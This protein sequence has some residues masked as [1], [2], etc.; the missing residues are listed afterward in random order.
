M[1]ERVVP[2][3]F[4]LLSEIIRNEGTKSLPRL[5]TTVLSDSIE[6]EFDGSP[7]TFYGFELTKGNRAKRLLAKNKLNLNWLGLTD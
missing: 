2:V 7:I 6:V 5:K 1:L 3:G 4:D